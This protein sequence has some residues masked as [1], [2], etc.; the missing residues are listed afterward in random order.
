METAWRSV[1]RN[2]FC[3][4]LSDRAIESL[5][6]ACETDDPRL[7]QKQTVSPV[8]LVTMMDEP[9]VQAC[10]LGF[11]GWQADELKTVGNV[12]ITVS[13]LCYYAD[14]ACGEPLAHHH[15]LNFVD[16]TPRP[17]MLR[18]L[19]HECRRELDRRRQERDDAAR[20]DPF[21]TPVVV[22]IAGEVG[23]DLVIA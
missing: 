2:G 12:A 15:F 22:R 11:C 1:W 18:E 17:L 4:L 8:P 7:I 3:P 14:M 16:D 23:A 20:P 10:V 21:D 9:P 5:A 6:V 13:Q 19:A